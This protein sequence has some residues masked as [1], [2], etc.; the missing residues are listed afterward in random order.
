MT[1]GLQEGKVPHRVFTMLRDGKRRTLKEVARELD[2]ENPFR[3]YGGAAQ[4][5]LEQ[6]NR[7]KVKREQ[8]RGKYVYWRDVDAEAAAS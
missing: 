2:P 7:G 6:F 1:P 8:V 3:Y 4:A 5:L